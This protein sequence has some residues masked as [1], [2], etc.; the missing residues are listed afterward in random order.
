MIRLADRLGCIAA[1]IFAAFVIFPFFFGMAWGGN[2]CD[3][4]PQ[5]Q[6]DNEARFAVEAILVLAAAA[7]I[8]LIVRSA[9]NS[10]AARRA[11]EGTS[12]IFVAGSALAVLV[13]VG[14]SIWASYR[15]LELIF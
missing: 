11:D 10:M 8:G 9:V 7:A 13:V 12:A 3:P 14:G 4:V 1:F 5:C 6:R 15:I 2:H